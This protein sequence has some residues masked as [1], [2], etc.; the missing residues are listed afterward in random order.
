MAYVYNMHL[1]CYVDDGD[2]NS[3]HVL[4]FPGGQGDF[5]QAETKNVAVVFKY[6]A[7][8]WLFSC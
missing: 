3:A 4:S 1:C 8:V 7:V 6:V 2:L 5:N